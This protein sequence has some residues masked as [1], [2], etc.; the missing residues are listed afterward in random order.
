MHRPRSVPS[1]L[2]A[3]A[4]FAFAAVALRLEERD[5]HVKKKRSPD[6]APPG[7]E[8]ASDVPHSLQV[9]RS[10]Q[11]GSAYQLVGDQ[12][13]RNAG[14]NDGK[15]T[16]E[17]VIGLGVALWSANAGM[18]S[19]VDALNIVYDEDEKRGVIKLNLISL[20]FTLGAVLALLVA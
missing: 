2:A 1:V 4:G 5:L 10:A 7:A 20:V 14:D 19:I 9:A 8:R 16:F 17:F 12:I 6:A 13:K 11:P 3:L 15:L 18:K